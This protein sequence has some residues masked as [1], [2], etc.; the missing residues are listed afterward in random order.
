[1]GNRHER[2]RAA[3][4]ADF[5]AAGAI[6]LLTGN[7]L[8]ALAA[9]DRMLADRLLQWIAAIPVCAT[10]DAIFERDRQP[11][12]FHIIRPARGPAILSGSCDDCLAR[13]PT[14]DA[15]MREV[16]SGYGRATGARLRVADAAHLHATG[17]RA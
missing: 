6:K 4:L 10:C 15:L 3:K 16:V 17:G 12:L 13:F 8:A 11:A 5:R 7:E 14:D 2:R 1:M 9:A